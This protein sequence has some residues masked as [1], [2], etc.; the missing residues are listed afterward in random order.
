MMQWQQ[1]ND[2]VA[3]TMM[4]TTMMQHGNGSG[5]DMVTGVARTWQLQR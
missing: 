5:K 2:T 1:H 3:T 4:V